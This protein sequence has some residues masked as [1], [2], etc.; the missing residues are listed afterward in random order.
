MFW[1]LSADEIAETARC[2]AAKPLVEARNPERNA[3][4]FLFVGVVTQSI[5]QSAKAF[6]RA[7]V[8]RLHGAGAKL[9]IAPRVAAGMSPGVEEGRGIQIEWS[10]GPQTCGWLTASKRLRTSI[11]I[12]FGV[13]AKSLPISRRGRDA[14]WPA[15]TLRGSSWPEVRL[16]RATELVGHGFAAGHACVRCRARGR[17]LSAAKPPR[18]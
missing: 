6:R 14:G 12:L 1:L 9:F 17:G 16:F 18:Q 8:A 3:R 7:S 4:C 5:A 13:V 10:V 2:A 15:A 11:D